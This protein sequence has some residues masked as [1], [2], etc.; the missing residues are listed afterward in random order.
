MSGGRRALSMA[1]FSRANSEPQLNT[2]YSAA[3]S[4]AIARANSNSVYYLVGRR[5]SPGGGLTM[6]VRQC[7]G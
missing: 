7:C 5:S 6:V 3:A 4:A 1:A 2:K